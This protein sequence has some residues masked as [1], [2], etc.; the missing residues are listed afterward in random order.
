MPKGIAPAARRRTILKLLAGSVAGVGLSRL[1]ADLAAAAE[2]LVQVGDAAISL[3]FD[4]SLRSRVIARQG[5]GI[6]PLTEFEPSETLRIA[7]GKHIDHFSFL[8]RRSEPV[9]DAH[10][11]GTRHVLRLS[12]IHI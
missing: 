6:E 1:G 3:E 5:G 4:S 11:R 8:D 2:P 9:E 12:L 7:G 10:G